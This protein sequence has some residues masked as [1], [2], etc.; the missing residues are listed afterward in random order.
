MSGDYRCTGVT[1]AVSLER[2]THQFIPRTM[3]RPFLFE[4]FHRVLCIQGKRKSSD[5]FRF[6]LAL[7][8]V[9]IDMVF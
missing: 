7:A 9:R 5:L 3:F 6:I 2:L 4:R 1:Y 8:G